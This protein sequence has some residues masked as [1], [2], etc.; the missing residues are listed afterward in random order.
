MCTVSY[1]P[2]ID[3]FIITSN[4]D[5]AA[6]RSAIEIQ[7]ITT[8]NGE[9]AFPQD[10][11]A[12]G[13][14]IGSHSNGR[15]ACLLNGAFEKHQRQ[16]PYRMSRGILLLDALKASSFDVFITSYDFTGIEPFTLILASKA[17]LFEL[18]WDGT[19]LHQKELDIT[20]R[21]IWA[22]A[23]LYSQAV[24]A[25]R[26]RLFTQWNNEHFTIT[27]KAIFDF[28]RYGG[29][30]DLDNGL[31]INRADIVQT[32]SITQTLISNEDTILTH[33][34]LLQNTTLRHQLNGAE[35]KADYAQ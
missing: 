25:E 4:R 30:K 5:E 34:D 28:H 6:Q 17:Q 3:G 16:L 18:V 9:I 12:G 14:W 2:T 29:T 21:Y 27:S 23:T 10:P 8:P 15:A 35:S 32:V 7:T 33:T 31:I 13:S 1:L 11:Q 19:T 24:R 26:Q 22:S 20:Q